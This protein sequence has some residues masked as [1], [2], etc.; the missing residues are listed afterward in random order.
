MN[1]SGDM[2]AEDRKAEDLKAKDR[3]AGDRMAGDRMAGG[4]L[5][6]ASLL[7]VLLMAHHPTSAGPH[8]LARFVH[9]GMMVLVVV[10]LA[11]FARF[12]ARRGLD[13]FPALLG[14]A[15]Y[16]AGAFGNLFAATVN[17][18]AV[19]ALAERGADKALFALAW[20]LNQ[21]AAY[22]AVYATAA[23]FALWGADMLARRP[24]TAGAFGIVA[25]VIPAGLLATGALDMRI[26]GAFIVYASISAFSVI[27]GIQMMR[28][29]D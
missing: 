3:K 10:I 24:R 5:V 6:V 12:A 25:G 1:R 23:A 22:A 15:F 8:W 17:G 20:E 27:I 11:A 29:K 16:A 26:A 21:A 2:M 28:G 18:F 7:V 13:R 14:L 9:G 4:A 19:P